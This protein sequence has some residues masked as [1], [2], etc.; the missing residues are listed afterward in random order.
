ML[1][2][3]RSTATRNLL[4]CG[5]KRSRFLAPRDVIFQNPREA[6]WYAHGGSFADCRPH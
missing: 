4:L 3:E 6:F 5:K 2:L 1:F